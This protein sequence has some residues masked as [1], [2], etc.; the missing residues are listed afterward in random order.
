MLGLKGNCTVHNNFLSQKA[1]V[2]EN[3]QQM[4]HA[5]DEE[6]RLGR[7]KYRSVARH[8][9]DPMRVPLRDVTLRDAA[10][11]MGGRMSGV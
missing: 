10:M 8:C 4:I 2:L 7:Q 5:T 6:A 9:C 3:R 11:R 1:R